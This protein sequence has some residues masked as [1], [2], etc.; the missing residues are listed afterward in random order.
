MCRW[1]LSGC[2][3]CLFGKIYFHVTTWVSLCEKCPLYPM[4]CK[5][6]AHRGGQ[7]EGLLMTWERMLWEKTCARLCCVPGFGCS[8]PNVDQMN[9]FWTVHAKANVLCLN[10]N[11]RPEEWWWSL[12]LLMAENISLYPALSYCSMEHNHLQLSHFSKGKFGPWRAAL[13]TPLKLQK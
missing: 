1:P 13:A 10:C 3:K 2:Q 12:T 6:R 4:R 11:Q 9:Y 5:S 8:S 7:S